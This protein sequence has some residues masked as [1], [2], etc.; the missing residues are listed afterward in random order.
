MASTFSFD[1]V[2][3]V[4]FMEVENAINQAQKELAQRFDFKGSKSSIDYNKT[5]KKITLIGDDDFKLKALIDIVDGKFAKRGVSLKTLNYKPKE[6]AF[7]GTVRQVIELISGLPSDKAKELSKLIKDSKIKVNT[8][9]E[10][11]KVKV[12]SAKKDDLQ[13]VIAYLKTA[14]FSLPLQFTNYR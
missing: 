14:N 11:S 10:G 4:N 2:S 7:E 12:S 8:Q 3:E 13:A 6:Q 1:V 9:I 5:D